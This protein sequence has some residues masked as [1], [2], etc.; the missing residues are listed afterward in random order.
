MTAS[1]KDRVESV[2]VGI[3]GRMA[4]LPA[5]NPALRVEL[6]GLQAWQGLQLGVLITP[7]TINLILLSGDQAVGHLGLDQRQSRRFPSGEYEFMGASD[8][9]LGDYQTC[10]LIS[11]PEEFVSHE[12]AREVAIA[13]L[14]ALFEA[15]DNTGSARDV[16]RRPLSRRGFLTGGTLSRT[17]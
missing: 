15:A 17:R 5:C 12:V 11:P 14:Y 16:P 6:I 13:A 2:F 7:W 10:S 3:A 9:A 1:T 4:G 8:P